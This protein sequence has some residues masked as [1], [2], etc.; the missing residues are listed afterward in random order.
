[1]VQHTEWDGEILSHHKCKYHLMLACFL[2][3]QNMHRRY[4]CQNS[5]FSHCLLT[6]HTPLIFSFSPAIPLKFARIP[7]SLIQ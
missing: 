6:H 5:N 1:M 4:W 7:S 3:I 2:L